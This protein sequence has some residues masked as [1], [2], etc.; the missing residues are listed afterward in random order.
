[1]NNAENEKE[2]E[3]PTMHVE[4]EIPWD[5]IDPPVRDLVRVLT[6]SLVSRS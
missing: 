4:P 3:A 5:D 6:S 1:M 2:A